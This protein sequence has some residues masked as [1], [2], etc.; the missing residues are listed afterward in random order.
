VLDAVNRAAAGA[1]ENYIYHRMYET[2]KRLPNIHRYLGHTKPEDFS[3]REFLSQF[4]Q[5]PGLKRSIDKAYEIVVYAL[6]Q[7]LTRFLKMEITLSIKEPD[8]E[9]LSDF[10]RFIEIV[11]GIPKGTNQA[12]FSAELHRLGVAHAADTGLDILSNF[13]PAIQVKH[14]TLDPDLVEDIVEPV[15]MNKVVIVCLGPEKYSIEAVLR[16]IGF[17][18]RI[19]GI[20]TDKDLD[21]WYELA[22]GKYR[23][24]LAKLLLGDLVTEF[25]R[26]F[27]HVEKIEDFLRAR[28]YRREDLREI[29]QLTDE[30]PEDKLL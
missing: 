16:Q 3:L 2:W 27:P 7:T 4:E 12:V 18:D 28:R 22:L 25:G 14:V 17:R 29:W 26:E 13:G 23:D 21:R 24:T 1:V 8:E 9:I 20:V 10:S 19:Q 5:Y 30:E 6:F 11:V 15:S